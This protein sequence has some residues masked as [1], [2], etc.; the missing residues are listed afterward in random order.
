MRCPWATNDRLIAYH[1]TEWGVPVHDER[2]LFEMLILEGAQAGLS[3]DTV[4][5]KRDRY[6]E[7][8][9]QFEPRKIAR[10]D[11]RKVRQLLADPGIIRNRA[12][13]A[14]TIGNARALLALRDELRRGSG[15]FDAF[16]WSFVG[17]KPIV[18]RR[19]TLKDIPARTP[20]AEAMS[21]ALLARGFKFVGPTI[22]YAFMQ[23]VG[24][25]DDHAAECFRVGRV[26]RVRGTS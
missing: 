13:V 26:R 22:C 16:L 5:R 1:D 6:R 24:M 12:K 2:R 23:A 4:L 11:A 9:D 18:T 8:F 15:S 19:R 21:K 7:V 25:V 20:P 17:G 14:A 10:Y 3:W